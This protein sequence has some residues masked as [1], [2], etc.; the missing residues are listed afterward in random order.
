MICL[1]SDYKYLPKMF[2][3]LLVKVID[4]EEFFFKLKI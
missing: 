2:N 3:I 4:F 1:W